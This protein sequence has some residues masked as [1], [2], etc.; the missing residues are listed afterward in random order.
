MRTLLLPALLALA[1]LTVSCDDQSGKTSTTTVSKSPV[2][3][4]TVVST[5]AG[6]GSYT[7]TQYGEDFFGNRTIKTTRGHQ[8]ATWQGD[9]LTAVFK[10]IVENF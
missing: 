9:L 6:D 4:D 1:A 10:A 2:A 7:R 5:R 3:K 8:N